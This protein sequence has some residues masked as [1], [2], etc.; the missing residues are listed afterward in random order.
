MGKST[1]TSPPDHRQMVSLRG[2]EYVFELKGMMPDGLIEMYRQ[3]YMD[4]FLM[5]VLPVDAET[6]G[7]FRAKSVRKV[8]NV[9]T[10]ARSH[11]IPSDVLSMRIDKT[12]WTWM[13]KFH[14]GTPNLLTRKYFTHQ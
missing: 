2:E 11:K 14:K 8:L 13:C 5:F 1:M 4:S 6:I 7:N 12:V 9:L 3:L 10:V